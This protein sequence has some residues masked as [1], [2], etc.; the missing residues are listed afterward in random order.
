MPPSHLLPLRSSAGWYRPVF[1]VPSM[2]R[3][4]AT[5]VAIPLPPINISDMLDSPIYVPFL[6]DEWK[7]IPLWS[8]LFTFF[9]LRTKFVRGARELCFWYDKMGCQLIGPLGN[10][11]N[12]T[13][14]FLYRFRPSLAIDRT[15]YYGVLTWNIIII[16]LVWPLRIFAVFA[17]I[18][19]RSKCS[20]SRMQ[21]VMGI[22]QPLKW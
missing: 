21:L 8:S 17:A 18:Q 22:G 7:I 2:L 14:L 20:A 5:S 15:G 11:I 6:L 10:V 1:S 16:I 19:N 9:A 3:T 12:A 4:V 13:F